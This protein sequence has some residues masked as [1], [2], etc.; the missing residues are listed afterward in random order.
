MGDKKREVC[1]FKGKKVILFQ[2]I[3]QNRLQKEGA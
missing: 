3:L 1:L 2:N